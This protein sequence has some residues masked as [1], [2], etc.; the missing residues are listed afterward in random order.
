MH[1][2]CGVLVS[3]QDAQIE[4]S[5][6]VRLF[7]ACAV[8]EPKQKAE[9]SCHSERTLALQGLAFCEDSVCG[10]GEN[11]NKQTVPKSRG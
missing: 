4:L 11:I 2:T 5:S 9:S 7:S 1:D 10:Q 8:A 6:L 3:E